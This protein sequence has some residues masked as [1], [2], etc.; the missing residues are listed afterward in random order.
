M[1]EVISGATCE[2]GDPS[3]RRRMAPVV[4]WRA[5]RI[6]AP[7]EPDVMLV[8][9]STLVAVKNGSQIAAKPKPHILRSLW[10]FCGG[11]S[12]KVEMCVGSG[13][14]LKVFD[15]S[16]PICLHPP[17]RHLGPERIRLLMF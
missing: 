3:A 8:A 7:N 15:M 4:R 2:Q 13:E 10:G 16:L 1:C 17:V 11:D 6:G 12:S 5:N 9:P 14:G